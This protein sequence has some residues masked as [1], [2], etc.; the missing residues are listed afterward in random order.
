MCERDSL[1]FGSHRTM[2]ACTASVFVTQDE[3]GGAGSQ[4][5][6]RL[7]W[8]IKTHKSSAEL[9][10]VIQSFFYEFHIS[11]AI[12]I[13][14]FF[15]LLCVGWRQRSRFSFCLLPW[16]CLVVYVCV[17]QEFNL[18]GGTGTK[19]RKNYESTRSIGVQIYCGC[20]SFHSF[21]ERNCLFS[22]WFCSLSIALS[23]L[24]I[25]SFSLFPL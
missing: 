25:Y 16:C 20:C 17:W 9:A 21:I 19:R 8:K 15:S 24:F 5:T 12:K 18:Q 6:T 1:L 22:I 13:R 2:V 3:W 10:R 4:Q 23:V 14:F 11:R 7:Q